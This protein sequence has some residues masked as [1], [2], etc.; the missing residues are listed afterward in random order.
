MKLKIL[1]CKSG[2]IQ[3]SNLE[4]SSSES[5]PVS[6]HL[7]LQNGDVIT[8]VDR[9]YFECLRSIRLRMESLDQQ[10]LLKGAQLNVWATGLARQSSRGRKG[11]IMRAVGQPARLEDE[12]DIFSLAEP[13]DIASV[14]AQ[15]VFAREWFR[16]FAHPE[17]PEA[18]S[19]FNEKWAKSF[20]LPKT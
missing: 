19:E 12:V 8:A 20:P 13:E 2:R 18:E 14:E 17:T 5:G 3:D 16:F 9:D 10:L 7:R 11:F 4:L 6:L 15:Q 1:D